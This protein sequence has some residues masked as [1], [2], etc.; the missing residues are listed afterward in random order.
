MV[1]VVVAGGT[2]GIGRTIVEE[3]IQ[4]G[5]HKVLIL[6]RKATT[7]PGLESV[8]MLE[9]NYADPVAITQLLQHHNVE[10]VIS[11]LALFTEESANARMH[12][13]DAAI[14]S[15][16]VTRFIPSEYGT[17]RKSHLDFTR[18]IFGW[19]LD[20]YGFPHC[21]SHMKPFKFALDFDNRMA[22]IPGDGEA[23]VTFLHSVDIAKYVVALLGEEG[24]WPET[25]AFASDRMTWNELITLAED[26]MGEKWDVTYESL[27]QLE[28]GE[29]TLFKQPEGSYH[30]PEEAARQMVAEW[31]IMAVKGVMDASGEG[32]RN[33]DF[34]DVQPITVEALIL[35]AWENK[36]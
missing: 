21:K 23:H 1:I 19:L 18:V 2:G 36:G 27:E 12:L 20:H 10:V 13:I 33:D 9:A 31:G 32:V 7:I 6:T 8:T 22:A 11:A 26:I 3:L 34:P 29:T 5:N 15:G 25:S 16:T 4:K 30:L 35:E 24:R 17:L 28:M 14:D